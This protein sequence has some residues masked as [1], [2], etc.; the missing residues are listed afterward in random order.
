MIPD[1]V[2]ETATVLLCPYASLIVMVQVPA[3]TGVTVA[4]A[5]GAFH[6]DDATVANAEQ[7]SD[8]TNAPVPVCVIANVVAYVE[9][10][11][12][13]LSDAGLTFKAGSV[14]EIVADALCFF[15]SFT[16]TVHVAIAVTGV[17]VSVA[18]GPLGFV[19]AIVTALPQVEAILNAPV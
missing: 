9:P 3:A 16:V 4:V 6:E 14:T 17:T 19:A 13:K 18:L 12:S 1:V 2:T 8:S 7:L 10:V 5:E 15:V 11:A